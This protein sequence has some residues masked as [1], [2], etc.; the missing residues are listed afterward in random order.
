MMTGYPIVENVDFKDVVEFPGYCV[1]NDGSIWSI[2][3]HG[4]K[5]RYRQNNG[6]LRKSS[7]DRSGY[8]QVTLHK[9]D[10]AYYCL[11]ARIVLEAFVGPC[12]PGM[13]ARHFPDR[14]TANNCLKNLAWATKQQNEADKAIH[15]TSLNGSKNHN[16]KLGETDSVLIRNARNSGLSFSKVGAKFGISAQHAYRICKGTA[17]AHTIPELAAKVEPVEVRS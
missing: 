12:P 14:A 7:R 5:G 8:Q 9:N 3:R 6:W 16:A 1:G 2:A 15:G 13:Q 10:R 17:W 11:V 4:N